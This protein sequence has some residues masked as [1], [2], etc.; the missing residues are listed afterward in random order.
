LR[1]TNCAKSNLRGME[2]VSKAC[3]VGAEVVTLQQIGRPLRSKQQDV[4]LNQRIARKKRAM[5]PEEEK[6]EDVLPSKGS[7]KRK[8]RLSTMIRTSEPAE[9][10][11]NNVPGKS[12]RK[13]CANLTAGAEK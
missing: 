7:G 6:K 12:L 13:K 9:R 3:D 2:K 10:E 8:E 5:K 4:S 1:L 11:T